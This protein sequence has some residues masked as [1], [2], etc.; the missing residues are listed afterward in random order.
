MCCP[1]AGIFRPGFLKGPTRCSKG[2]EY[3]T[4]EGTFKNPNFSS[5]VGHCIHERFWLKKCVL[6]AE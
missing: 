5:F 4:P 1:P 6:I 3:Y 2:V